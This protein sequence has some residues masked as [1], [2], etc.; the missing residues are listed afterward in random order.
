[1]NI[2]VAMATYNGS[3]YI[4]EQLNS[5]SN[6]R[7]LPFEL[8]VCDDGSTDDTVSIIREF[9]KSAPYPV[10]MHEN[11][12]NLGF[13]DNFMKVAGLCEGDWISFCDQDDIWH[14][15]KL[16]KIEQ[17]IANSFSNEL[18]LVYHR[19]E[20]V[21]EKLVPIGKRLP[22]FLSNKI[23]CNGTQNGFWFVGGCV[24]TFK[25]SILTYVDSSGRPKD[26]YR[27]TEQATKEDL[28]LLPHD[29]WVCMVANVVGDVERVTDILS[30]YRRHCDTVTGSHNDNSIALKINKAK[31]TGESNYIFLGDSARESSIAFRVMSD[32][33]V[34][35]TIRERMFEASLRFESLSFVFG[36]R[37]DLYEQNGILNRL[38]VIYSMLSVRGYFGDKFI[39]LGLLSFIKDVLFV[40]GVLGRK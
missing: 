39:S 14:T 9:A 4:K 26:N 28:P 36:K 11:K 40:V 13:A 8:V 27:P 2:S 33:L 10:R 37:A 5:I 21:N 30:L 24:M 19:A 18:V 7:S 20:L 31:S 16:Y 32:V 12:F 3:K 25:A 15:E 29:K 23:Y 22:H 17:T 6:Q 34:D 35:K 38:T 1:M